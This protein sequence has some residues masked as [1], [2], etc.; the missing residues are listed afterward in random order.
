[1]LDN[2]FLGVFAGMGC[3]R[4]VGLGGLSGWE[5]G[6]CSEHIRAALLMKPLKFRNL[7]P[8]SWLSDLI[9]V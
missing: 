8:A 5:S 6:P 7:G 1:M 4:Q 2:I 9:W 3:D